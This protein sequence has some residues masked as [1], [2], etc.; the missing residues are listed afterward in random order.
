MKKNKTGLKHKELTEK[1]IKAFYEVY[2]ELGFGFLESVYQKAMAIV[3]RDY[4]LKVEEEKQIKVYFQGKVIGD[5]RADLWVNNI[6]ILELKAAKTLVK[7]YE[8]QLLNYLR[9][10]NVEIGLLLNCGLKPQFKR[11]IFDNSRKKQLIKSVVSV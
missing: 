4:G 2:N 3:F 1:I 5:Y 7:E 10:T 11:M 9:A 6:I 8:A